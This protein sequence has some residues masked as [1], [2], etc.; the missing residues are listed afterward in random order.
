MTVR[1]LWAVR[2]HYLLSD[3][4]TSPESL[5]IS[6]FH[7]KPCKNIHQRQPCFN[8]QEANV[9]F[10]L[11]PS[12]LSRYVA[13]PHAAPVR[14]PVPR[15]AQRLPEVLGWRGHHEPSQLRYSLILLSFSWNSIQEVQ[16]LVSRIS[17]KKSPI[18]ICQMRFDA[19][20]AKLYKVEHVKSNLHNIAST[21]KLD[22]LV[23]T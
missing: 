19:V 18:K 14:R 9:G 2:A 4:Q 16:T 23:G 7:L 8:H 13:R 20:T 6:L 17:E 21:L 15:L 5:T 22:N 1:A 3:G 11:T 10:Q 12:T